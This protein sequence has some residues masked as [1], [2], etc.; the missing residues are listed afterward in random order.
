[1]VFPVV[2][3]RFPTNVLY[4]LLF[5]PIRATC[6]AHLIFLDLIILII[7]GEEYKFRLHAYRKKI[8]NIGIIGKIGREGEK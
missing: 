2:S 5:S 4:A 7:L 8:K 3:F 6:P 1:L